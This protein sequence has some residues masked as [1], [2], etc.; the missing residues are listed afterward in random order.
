MQYASLKSYFLSTSESQARFIRLKKM[1]EDP[2]SEVYLMFLHSILPM[3]TY[4]NKFLQREDPL[5]H[6]LLP[7]L[8]G[9]IKNVFGKFIKEGGL[10]SVDFKNSANAVDRDRLSIGFLTRQ[11]I[12]HLL[13]DGDVSSRSYSTFFDGVRAFLI[14]SSEYLLKW[15]PIEDEFLSHAT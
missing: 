5:I 2:M 6:V 8:K 1:F 10:A 12:N 3:F 11:K 13:S 9:L 7:Q 15:C 14:C 4:T